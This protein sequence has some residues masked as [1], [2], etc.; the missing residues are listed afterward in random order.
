MEITRKLTKTTMAKTH[1]KTPN[2][3]VTICS[4]NKDGANAS[5]TF[6]D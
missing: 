4:P 5:K 2:K 3:K 1:K 6:E